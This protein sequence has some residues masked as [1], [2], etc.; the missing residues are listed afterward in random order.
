M[1][2]D[3]PQ[4]PVPGLGRARMLADRVQG[5]PDGVH[6]RVVRRILLEFIQDISRLERE[7]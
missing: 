2:A 7:Q 4:A 5:I 6:Q 1:P 3:G